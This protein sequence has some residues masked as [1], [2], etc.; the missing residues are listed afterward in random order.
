M[1]LREKRAAALKAAQEILDH[2]KSA[3]RDLTQTENAEIEARFAEVESLD[4]MIAEAEMSEALIQRLSGFEVKTEEQE[5]AEALGI[6]WTPSPTYV[7]AK[8]SS[9]W[10]KS[11]ASTLSRTAAGMGVKALLSGEV[12]V[13]AAV[14]I[15]P[16]PVSPARLLDLIQRV[17]MADASYTYLRQTVR[18]DNAAVVPD[19]QS[20]PISVYTFEEVN[21]RAR[22][23]AHLSEPFPL[24]YLSDYEGLATILDGEMRE[25]VLKEVERQTIVGD[26]EGDNFTGILTTSGVRDVPFAADLLTTVRTARTVLQNAGESPTAWVLNPTDAA[27]LELMREDGSTGGFLMAGGA[28]E[29]IFGANVNRVTSSLLP[30]GTAILGDWTKIKLRV[31]E[32]EHT[33]A[34]TQAGDLFAK[35]QVQLRTEGRYNIDLLRPAAFAVV[36]LTA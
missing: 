34:A 8:Q 3:G 5:R 31:R 4:V 18:D 2:A 29:V 36:H 6:D 12:A 22:V 26:G 28:Y 13:P 35:N 19:G 23:I 10:A 30:Q 1:N 15:V 17:P 21:G 32:G 7:Q 14:G 16:T 11:V 25:G 27:A 33:L 24:R 9:P 20:K